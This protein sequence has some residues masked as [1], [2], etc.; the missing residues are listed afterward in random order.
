MRE[1]ADAGYDAQVDDAR[2]L[3][4]VFADDERGKTRLSVADARR[5]SGA[6]AG[7]LG[8]NVLLRPVVERFLLPTVTYAGGPGEI[9]YFAQVSAVAE[10]LGAEAPLV[11][12]RW[13]CTLLEPHVERILD[14]LGLA[15]ADL[16]DPHAAETR[17]ARESLPDPVR[18]ALD[19]LRAGISKGTASL[20]RSA[21]GESPSLIPPA[22]AEGLER[23]LLGRVARA[24][25]R[26]VAAQK[27]LAESTMRDVA[28]ARGALFPFGTRQ[29]RALN[30]LPTLA[31]HG[32]G[33]LEDMR[34]AA[35][36]H[37]ARIL[38]GRRETAG[39]A[40]EERG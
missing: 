11:V 27:R 3:S 4:L 35:E 19:D 13:S 15:I 23:T 38:G 21:T 10:A 29:E 34:A 9:A 32:V 22:V 40:A 25:R 18:R 16:A 24:E 8:P 26:V 2:G 30:L 37:A 28:T 31:R 33:L 6:E 12:P 39:A 14:R 1:I 20:A 5:A 17:M 36:S 7:T